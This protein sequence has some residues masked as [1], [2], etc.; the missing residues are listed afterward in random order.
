MHYL[1]FDESYPSIAKLVVAGWVVEQHRLN[2]N[3]TSLQTLLRTS[4]V[5]DVNEMLK[6]LEARAVIATT[7]LDP[8]L[9]RAGKIDGTDDVPR[10]T[11]TN[12]VWA[13]CSTFLV[14]ALIA[15]LFARREALSTIDLYHD[16]KSLTPAHDEARCRILRN[17]VI[18]NAKD[19]S[20]ARNLE[21]FRKLNIRR[22]EPVAKPSDYG[23]ADKF[24]MGVWVSDKLCTS[25][26]AAESGQFSRIRTTNMSEEVRR[27]IQQFDGKK[28]EDD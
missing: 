28:F 7:V 23:V 27:T 22:I 25:A 12:N 17:S 21:M 4:R 18:R 8:A 1:F 5:N 9:F 3:F 13:T 2:R 26:H 19:F 20:T 10:M 24:Q 6:N 14:T 11:R 16:P 15:E